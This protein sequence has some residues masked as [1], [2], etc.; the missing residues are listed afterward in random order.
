MGC[1]GSR[2]EQRDRGMVR[3]SLTPRVASELDRFGKMRPA[4]SFTPRQ[5]GDGTC[6]FTDTVVGAGRE[7]E[8][9]CG[10]HKE[11]FGRRFQRGKA[12][13]FG[14]GEHGVRFALSPLLAGAGVAN[15]CGHHGARFARRGVGKRFGGEAG[16]F[17]H[18][19]DAVKERPGESRTVAFD[20]RGGTVAAVRRVAQ[21]TTWTWVH[22]CDELKAR[23]ESDPL[24]QP[25]DGDFARFERFAQCFEH[26]TGKFR[27]FV[28]KEDAVVGERDFARKDPACCA[29][30]DDRRKGRRMVRGAKRA[31]PPGAGVEWRQ[32][33]MDRCALQRFGFVKRR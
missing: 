4:D 32:E 20:L 31:L 10:F 16:R 7:L 33:R 25:R 19:V 18:E 24:P 28:E 9:L 22:C 30:T 15:A 26:G 13:E 29:A 1:R 11:L 27:E 12:V 3:R 5:I 14:G 8:P 6:H 2:G 17:D 21:V 23:G